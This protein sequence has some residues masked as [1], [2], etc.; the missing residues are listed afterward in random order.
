M[1]TSDWTVQLDQPDR[2]VL[3]ALVDQDF[4]L[5]TSV[6]GQEYCGFALGFG[7]RHR[8]DDHKHGS[9]LRSVVSRT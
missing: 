7:N 8:F 3:S 9:C 6:A 4:G 1:S 2:P 5:F